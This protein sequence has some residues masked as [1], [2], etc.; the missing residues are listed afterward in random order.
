MVERYTPRRA[1]IGWNMENI[2]YSLKSWGI[3]QYTPVTTGII[4]Y[5]KPNNRL[6]ELLGLPY[7]YGL[8]I[9]RLD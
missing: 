1:V 4:Y 5:L 9:Y 7:L 2:Q 8:P 6:G 3:P